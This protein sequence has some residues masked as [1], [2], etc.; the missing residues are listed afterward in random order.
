VVRMKFRARMNDVLAIRRFHS[1]LT[2]MAKL[3][4][5][6]ILRLN[7]EKLYLTSEETVNEGLQS[8]VWVEMNPQHYFADYFLEGVTP[9]ANQI[10]LELNTD[11]L[12]KSLGQ[13]KSTGQGAPKSL[14]IKLTR[15]F[16][17]PCLSFEIESSGGGLGDD[18]RIVTHDFPVSL[19]SR[20]RWAT[21]IKEPPSVADSAADVSLFMP[22]MKRFRHLSDRYKSLGHHVTITATRGG[23]LSFGM[24][25][26]RVELKTTF[27]QLEVPK[28]GVRLAGHA[29]N[30]EADEIEAAVKIDIKKLHALLGVDINFKRT[31]ANFVHAKTI[32]FFHLDEDLCLQYI[33][34]TV[35]DD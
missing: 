13:L 26:E 15:K 10:L 23:Q 28:D 16:D 24:A 17:S 11:T 35:I 27:K 33:I 2:S 34:P 14:K 4:K 8:P 12:A 21:E 3:S 1:I 7:K 6:A 29:P 5:T 32:H 18:G 25:S 20:K 22:D 19:V 30:A 9:E 31:L